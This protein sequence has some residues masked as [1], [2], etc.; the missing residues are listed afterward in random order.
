MQDLL[1]LNSFRDTSP[2][3]VALFGSIGNAECGRFFLPSPI[4]GRRL[5]VIASVGEGWEHVSV[6]RQNR[7]PNWAEME[8][9]KGL[10]LGDVV[11]MQLHVPTADH[12]NFH[13]HCLH[14]W[15][16]LDVDIPTPPGWM[17]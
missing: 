16:P 7:C 12:I 4:D 13:P 3:V 14:I 17:V 1:L 10:F 11:A 5:I 9:V 6:S 2:D 8:Y 15:R